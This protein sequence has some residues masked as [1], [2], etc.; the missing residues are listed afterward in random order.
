MIYYFILIL[1]LS[2]TCTIIVNKNNISK[3]KYLMS[4]LIYAVCVP[5]ILALFLSLYTILFLRTSMLDVSIISYFLPIITMVMV[6]IILNRKIKISKLPG[7]TRLS[8]LIIMISISF[9]IL[10]ILQR[11]YFG[12]LI[13]GSFTHLLLVFIIIMV[14]VKFAWTKFLK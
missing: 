14:I 3:V 2:I 8:S 9:I 10:F 11:S 4:L 13:L 1:I 12:V 6:L 7:F 5:G